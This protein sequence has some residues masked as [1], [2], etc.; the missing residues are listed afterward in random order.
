MHCINLLYLIFMFFVHYYLFG[1]V[2]CTL[3]MSDM[4]HTKTIDL[5]FNN[6]IEDSCDYLDYSN[7]E[8]VLNFNGLAILQHNIHGVLGKQDSLKL[9]LNNI[10]R[11]CR[12]QVIML[13]ETWL[14][15]NNVKRVK[16][17]G[18]SFVCS[19]RK[20]KCGGELES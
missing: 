19:H 9:L 11:D 4:S 13:A 16:I 5:S 2:V 8:T 12:V 1:S 18:D 20:S 14:N 10:R 3:M 15:K 17:P 7:I 6:V